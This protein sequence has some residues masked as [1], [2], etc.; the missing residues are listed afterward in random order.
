MK[1]PAW[2]QFDESL[3]RSLNYKRTIFHV[4]MDKFLHI[5]ISLGKSLSEKLQTNDVHF[6]A[7]KDTFM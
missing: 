3:L 7:Q 6:M 5:C 2:D 4:I 1:T